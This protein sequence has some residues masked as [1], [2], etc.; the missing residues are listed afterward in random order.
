METDR[1]R[2]F[3]SAYLWTQCAWREARCSSLMLSIADIPL[4]GVSF[5]GCICAVLYN[6]RE[7][8][9][10]TYRGARVERWSADGA[11]IRQGI[12]RLE[13]ERAWK[14]KPGS[15]GRRWRAAWAVPSVRA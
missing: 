15:C 8:R 12:Y 2:S 10:A 13:A 7:Y 4:A 9:L 5:T 3:P 1:G 6:G 11:Q 14:G